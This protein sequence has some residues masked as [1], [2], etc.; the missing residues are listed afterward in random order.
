MKTQLD[1]EI[2]LIQHAEIRELVRDVLDHCPACFWSMP[3]ATTGKYHPAI[4]LGEGGLIRHTK[5]VVRLTEHLL[6]MCGIENDDTEYSLAL[7]A[8]I[9]HDCVKKYDSEQYTAFLHPQR[10]AALISERGKALIAAGSPL[11][12]CTVR[13]I[14]ATVA[15][16]MGRWSRDYRTGERLPEPCT[17]LQKLVHTADYLASRKD[18]TL[19]GIV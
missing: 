17:P 6:A 18:L 14:A 7:A 11:A 16:H 15:A 4:S 13:S 1:H 8:A 3:A 2:S 19:E 12:E 10:A 9:L 5:A